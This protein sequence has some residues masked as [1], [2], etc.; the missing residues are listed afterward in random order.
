MRE[1]NMGIDRL[2]ETSKLRVKVSRAGYP[3]R[4]PHESFWTEFFVPAAIALPRL[5][6]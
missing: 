6:Y 4:M 5:P 3:V 1:R 2:G